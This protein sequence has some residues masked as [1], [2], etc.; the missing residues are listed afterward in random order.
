VRVFGL[1]IL[2]C[3]WSIP[4]SVRRRNN[5]GNWSSSCRL[6][7]PNDSSGRLLGWDGLSITD[8]EISLL[9]VRVLLSS[10]KTNLSNICTFLRCP[11][12]L[13]FQA[14]LRWREWILPCLEDAIYCRTVSS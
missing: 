7:F 1:R 11:K 12:S 3:A 9:K 6:G 13:N 5:N 10:V 14:S 8:F 2:G 4:N